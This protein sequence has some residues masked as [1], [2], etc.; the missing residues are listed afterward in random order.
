MRSGS[1]SSTCGGRS[2]RRTYEPGR[3]TIEVV[4]DPQFDDNVGTWTI[5]DGAVRRARRRPDVRLPVTALGSA[6]LGGF[7]FTQLCAA[8]HAEEAA[9]GGALRADAVFGA[10]HRG[11]PR[12]SEVDRAVGGRGRPPNPVR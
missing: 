5:E 8:G 11:A 12:S 4:C 7:P 6:Y 9:R 1:G 10:P 3:V 2:P